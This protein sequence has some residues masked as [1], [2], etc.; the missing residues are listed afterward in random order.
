[1]SHKDL[2]DWIQQMGIDLQRFSSELSPAAPK[3]ARQK[4]WAP[5]VDVLEGPEHI[6]VRVELPG[7]RGNQFVINFNVEKNAL[8]LR[9]ERQDVAADSGDVF[10]P[11]Q[12]EIDYGQFAREVKLPD[13]DINVADAQA[14]LCNGILTIVVPKGL[15]ETTT[16]IIER[17]ITVR[18]TK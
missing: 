16:M 4:E 17:T 14:Q 3:L 9:G 15:T 6:I 7:V 5:R 8:I 10:T 12:L 1:M 13:G 18:R 2:E 11:H